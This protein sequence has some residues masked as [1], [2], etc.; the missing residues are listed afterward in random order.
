MRSSPTVT[1]VRFTPSRPLDA[2]AGL[3]GFVTCT[4]EDLF[5]IDGVALRR[6]TRGELRLSFPART[7]SSGRR[8]TILRPLHAAAWRSMERQV[9]WALQ[10]QGVL[11]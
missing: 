6:T 9:F 3:L 1:H 4:V 7:D 11:S 10:S 2:H 5:E 8:H